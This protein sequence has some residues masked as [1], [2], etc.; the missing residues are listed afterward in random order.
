MN[1]RS[2]SVAG[3]LLSGS[4]GAPV[5][6]GFVAAI[7]VSILLPAVWVRQTSAR[8]CFYCAFTYYL[9]ALWS[10]SVVA[11]IRTREYT[12]G[13]EKRAVTEVRVLNLA[14]LDRP[15]KGAAA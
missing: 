3:A 14:K 9:S 4:V 6:T 8:S 10:V 11:R 13:D 12:K 15:A 1:P 2:R 7:A 5:S